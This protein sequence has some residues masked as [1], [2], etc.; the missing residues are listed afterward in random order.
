M[1]RNTERA[2]STRARLIRVA[3]ERFARHGYA[4]A[5]TESI[6][7]EAGLGRGALY[8]HFTDKAALFQAVCEQL[9][10][11]AL[12]AVEVVAA[13]EADPVD[14]LVAG[15]IA[16]IEFIIRPEVR[17]ILL[18]DAPTVLGWVRWERLDRRLS[19]EA[20][21]RGLDVAVQAGRLRFDC[22]LDVATA[23]LN[24]ALSGLALRVGAPAE[25]GVGAGWQPAV[26]ML[27]NAFRAPAEPAAASRSGPPPST[28]L[29]R[30][31]S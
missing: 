7:D 8:H 26:R 18:V 20:L 11:E 31:R 5:G 4:A 17:Q 24:G 15:S 10:E 9:G 16:W 27:F 13:V 28:T 1:T 21:R 6:L 2:A 3:R 23:L 29:R 19:G 14:A 12:A 25:D 22:D 30:S